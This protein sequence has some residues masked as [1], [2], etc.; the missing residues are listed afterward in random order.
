MIGD[1]PIDSTG[2]IAQL[3]LAGDAN[4]DGVVDAVDL[5]NLALHWTSSDA[6]WFDGDFTYDGN[7]DVADPSSWP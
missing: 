1:E 7:V 4:L 3:T 2:L 6:F 5:G